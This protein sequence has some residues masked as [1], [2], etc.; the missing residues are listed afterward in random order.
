MWTSSGSPTVLP[1]SVELLCGALPAAPGY[2]K[3]FKVVAVLVCL[4]QLCSARP[5]RAQNL[6]STTDNS[7][8]LVNEVAVPR[9]FFRDYH[10][11]SIYAG[12]SFGYPRVLSDL[13]GQRLLIIGARLTSHFIEFRRTTVNY[14]FDLKPLALYSNDVNG[15]R[16]YRYGSGAALGLQFLPHTHWRYRPFFDV[17]GGFLAFTKET[18]IPD[19]RRVNMTLDFGPGLYIPTGPDAH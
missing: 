11:F 12:Q 9:T 3:M 17:N 14:N 1:V 19:T 4:A 15:P 18:P 2:I 7:W 16:E 6:V 13:S 8:D 10:E 5:A